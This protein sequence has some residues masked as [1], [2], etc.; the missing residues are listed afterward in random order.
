MPTKDV[1]ELACAGLKELALNET[2]RNEF[3]KGSLFFKLFKDASRRYI[4]SQSRCSLSGRLQILSDKGYRLGVEYVGEENHDPPVI[5][6]F[7]EEYLAS[8]Q[9]FSKVGL[10]PQLGFDLSAVGLLVSQELAFLNAS[11]ILSAAAE[12]NIPVMISM[13]HSS[14]VDKI[15]EVYSKLAP[16]YLNVGITV[17]A[18]LHRTIDDLSGIIGYGRKIRLVKGVYNES[19]EIALPRGSEL[20]DRYMTLLDEVLA[21]NVPVSCAT[22]D[23]NLIKRL[24]DQSYQ[25]DIHEL[26]MLHG[27]QPDMLRKAKESGFACRIA[28][29]Y[30]DSWYLHFLHRLA[31]SPDNVIE[32][33]ADFYDP[34]RIAFGAG[35]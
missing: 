7:V 2:C 21:A 32:A 24:I 18:H 10:T 29:V 30:G 16:A 11:T 17:Q 25:R 12:H 5:Q 28:A 34:S 1:Y 31:E 15:L 3:N 19:R 6:A 9:L 33:L 4:I 22:Q 14:A 27:V 8:I 13:E 26:E 35:Y 23:P 20:D